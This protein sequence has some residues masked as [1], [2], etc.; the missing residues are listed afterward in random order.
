MYKSRLHELCQQ[1]KWCL[2]EYNATKL[3]LVHNPRF[4]AFITINGA[5]FDMVQLVMSSKEAQ[6]DAV[7][8]ALAHFTDLQPRQTNQPSLPASSSKTVLG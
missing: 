1:R 3:V 2:P 5:A 7:R 8:L 6:N 4:S